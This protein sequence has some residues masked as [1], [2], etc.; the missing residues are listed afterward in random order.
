MRET[1]RSFDIIIITVN[2]DD[3]IRRQDVACVQFIV[4]LG[5]HRQ[6]EKDEERP[7]NQHVDTCHR[8]L[9][10]SKIWFA[11]VSPPVEDKGA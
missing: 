7:R 2:E 11:T 6:T 8:S 3:A 10:S 1:R 4:F 5:R 9:T